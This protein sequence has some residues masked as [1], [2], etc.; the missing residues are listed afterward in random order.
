[1]KKTILILRFILIFIITSCSGSK[2]YYNNGRELERAGLIP[3][4]VNNY[5]ESLRRNPSNIKA[6][7]A[8]AQ[9]GRIYLEQI[10]SEFYSAHSAGDHERAVLRFHSASRLDRD[11]KNLGVNSTI[12]DHYRQM[13]QQSERIFIQRIMERAEDLIAEEKFSEAEREIN[14]L[15]ELNVNNLEV[16]DLRSLAKAEPKYRA[17]MKAF[18]D[19]RYRAAYS[20]FKEVE[21]LRP[22]YKDARRMM[23]LAL[24]RALFVIAVMPMES[25]VN[26]KGSDQVILNSI[27]GQII[28]A[29]N[30]F[31]RVIDRRRTEILMQERDLNLLNAMKSTRETGELLGASALLF[32]KITEWNA[33]EGQLQSVTRPGYLAREV[34][35]KNQEGV[36]V[37]TLEYSK[38]QYTVFSKENQ[39][40]CTFSYQLIST[41]T[42][43]ILLSESFDS[44]QSDR[45]EYATF[46]G[47]S[48]MLFPGTWQYINKP[49]PSDR[50]DTNPRAKRELDRLLR[51]RQNATDI[52]TL[53]EQLIQSVSSR[54]ASNILS[55]NPE[56]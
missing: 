4:A 35:Y 9:T 43:E 47:E 30:P 40:R 20:S 15:I 36:E 23:D 2:R 21:E 52:Q 7:I 48:K 18:N 44:R 26:T 39:V 10:L 22:G 45:I 11:M 42:G 6:Q 34:K 41:E 24:E 38:V 46:R 28:R 1:M 51:A 19:Q 27:I 25:A 5:M 33:T 8:L 14:K 31:V 50:V 54:V 17:A 29:N 49:H 16:S 56:K 32:C 13:Y 55:F 3:E 37:V 53:Q 12:S